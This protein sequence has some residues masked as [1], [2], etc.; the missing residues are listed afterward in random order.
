MSESVEIPAALA[1]VT[2]SWMTTALRSTRVI[3]E[4]VVTAV[5]IE[6]LGAIQ[7]A[8]RV[9]RLRLTYDSDSEKLPLSLIAKLPYDNLDPRHVEIIS[10]EVRVYQELLGQISI[11]TPRCYF[12]GSDAAAG[13]SIL[14]LED[15]SHMRRVDFES[16]VTIAEAEILLTR[17]ARHQAKWWGH[18]DLDELD[19][20]NRFPVP[21][22]T[23]DQ[24]AREWA[25]WVQFEETLSTLQPDIFLPPYFLAVGQR[26]FSQLP[27]VGAQMMAAPLTLIHDDLHPL[28]LLF[29]EAAGDPPFVVLD[30]PWCNVGPGFRDIGYF[31]I[32]SLPVRARRQ[33]ER[34]LLQAYHAT[35]VEQSV[36]DYSFDQCWRDYRLSLFKPLHVLVAVASSFDLQH[37]DLPPFIKAAT[38]RVASFAED[39][40]VH[41]FLSGA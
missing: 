7:S 16:G 5:Q 9:V 25:S 6:D 32:Y 38:N 31:M 2:A 14:L 3:G 37:P 17:F 35:L 24:R 29:A 41:E 10:R 23:D 40:R 22:Y 33:G 13:R 27:E 19:L 20:L 21:V 4:A 39:H 34:A 36:R 11:P 30:W 12:A 1:A 15:C 26:Y 18:P 8:A 28:N